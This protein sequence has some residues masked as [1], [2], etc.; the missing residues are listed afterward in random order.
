MNDSL[1][2]YLFEDRSTRVQTVNLTQTWA[3]ALGHQHYPPTI[4]RL[5]GELSAAAVLLT[6]NIKFDGSL[7]LQLQGDGPISLIVVECDTSLHVRAT[8]KMRQEFVCPENGTLQT[9]LNANGNGRFAV[10]L[11]PKNRSEG[12]QPYQGIVPMQGNSVAHVLEH[13]MKHSEQLNTRLW[14]AANDEKAC[15]LLLQQLPSTGG[16]LAATQTTDE[17]WERAVQFAE[18]LS[19]EELL[20]TDEDTLIHRLYWEET[21]IAYEPIA[22]TWFCPCTRERVANMLKMLGSEEIASILSERENIEI[23]CDFCGKPYIFDPVDC[24]KLFVN[25]DSF[26]VKGNKSTH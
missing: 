12:M 1:K 9:L 5:L 6:S 14:L 22:V 17:T 25:P 7:I 3:E 11:D 13:Y 21:L 24:A 10:I 2:K 19:T 4:R 20:S 18:T 16:I 15:G 8:V 23:S 26:V